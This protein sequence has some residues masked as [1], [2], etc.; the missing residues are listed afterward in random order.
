MDLVRANACVGM[1]KDYTVGEFL[2][3]SA[4]RRSLFGRCWKT[5]ETIWSAKLIILVSNCPDNRPRVWHTTFRACSGRQPKYH[6]RRENVAI[7]LH[8]LSSRKKRQ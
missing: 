2:E 5:K 4:E 3:S 1:P 8:V 6:S 7:I